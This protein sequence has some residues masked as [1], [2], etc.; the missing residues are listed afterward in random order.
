MIDTNAPVRTAYYTALNG[1]VSVVIPEQG[2]TAQ[3]IPVH[4]MTP[5]STTY[6]Y[7]YI[8]NQSDDGDV[9]TKTRDNK[10]ATEHL[11]E[12][13]IVDG[14]RL[15]DENQ[16][17]KTIDDIANIVLGL[18]LSGTPL[19]FV[20]IGNIVTEFDSGEYDVTLNDTHLVITRK[21]VIKHLLSQN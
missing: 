20:G 4:S 11:I 18:V 6:P 2:T 1:L 3:V 21:I 9:E 7:I 13:I 12:V 17:Y 10:F 16:S 8:G 5:V 15:A 19:T 14:F